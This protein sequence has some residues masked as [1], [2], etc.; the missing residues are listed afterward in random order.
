[1]H[2]HI[3]SLLH[4]TCF[5][6]QGGQRQTNYNRR[7]TLYTCCEPVCR[8]LD[9]AAANSWFLLSSCWKEE[10]YTN[11]RRVLPPWKPVITHGLSW[12]PLNMYLWKF[13]DTKTAQYKSLVTVCGTPKS[14]Y[15]ST[16]SKPRT[17]S[18]PRKNRA[19]QVGFT[20]GP[21]Y[22]TCVKDLV[23]SR[24]RMYWCVKL[25]FTFL[26]QLT[27]FYSNEN[28]SIPCKLKFVILPCQ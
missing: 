26:L 1:M 17:D 9:P 2:I 16:G 6:D 5:G 24:G 7:Q 18:R 14:S 21:Y 3:Y 22:G 19:V 4:E 11:G 28:F 25:S 12:V 15:V 8:F 20:A 10:V 13:E 23:V 27:T